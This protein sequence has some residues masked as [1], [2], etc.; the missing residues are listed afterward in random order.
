M[1]DNENGETS[2]A[3]SNHL[4]NSELP[5]NSSANFPTEC[6]RSANFRI[7]HTSGS[8]LANDIGYYIGKD[9]DDYTKMSLLQHPWTPPKNYNFPFST[10]IVKGKSVEHYIGLNHLEYHKDWLV[11]SDVMNGLFC[12]FCPW[13]TN[14][15]EGGFQKNVALK[16]LVSEPLTNFKK[17]S[18]PTSN[19]INHSNTQYHKDAVTSGKLFLRTYHNPELVV[20][21]LVNVA[22]KIQEEE[23]RQKLLSIAKTVILCGR[24][25]MP[26]RGHRDDGPIELETD[27]HCNEGNFRA[28]L[29]FRVDAGDKVLEDHLN[30]ASSRSTCLS[31]TTQNE[32]INICKLEI[33][34]IIINRV[35]QAGMDSIIFDE[36][37]D[38]SHRAQVS[39]V[40]PYVHFDGAVIQ[41]REDFIIFI[42]AFSDMREAEL[43]D[44]EEV[45]DFYNNELSITAIC[46]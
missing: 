25:N 4:S 26:L 35:L 17:L 39:L 12:K 20:Q 11:L 14:R 46:L 34:E 23:K 3:K 18:G 42:D 30:T 43:K 33:T 5:S 36:T 10:R 29:R 27:P 24:Q 16:T 21:N 32:I 6:Q 7:T 45:N 41:I 2:S 19:L 1:L 15:N 28:L 44:A 9:I 8:E 37:S 40:L 38:S 31:K 13:F 22:G